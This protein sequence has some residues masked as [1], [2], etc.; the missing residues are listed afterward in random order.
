MRH[1]SE[2]IIIEKLAGFSKRPKDFLK[3]KQKMFLKKKVQS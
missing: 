2:G 3:V 1:R